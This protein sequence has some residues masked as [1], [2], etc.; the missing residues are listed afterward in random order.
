MGFAL[1]TDKQGLGTGEVG[2]GL[3]PGPTKEGHYMCVFLMM[4]TEIFSIP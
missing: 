4:L 2:F 1:T 3:K